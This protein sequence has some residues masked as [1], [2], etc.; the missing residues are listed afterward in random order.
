MIQPSASSGQTSMQQERDE[1]HELADRQLAADH[2]AAAE[3][4][5]GG[6]PERGQEEQAGRKYASTEPARIV[7]CRTASARPRKRVAHVVLAP[8][9]LHHL[10]PDDRLVGRLGEVA[11]ARLDEPRDRE[12]LVREDERE[13]RDRRHRQRRVEREPRVHDV[14]TIAAPVII[15]ALWT[16]WTTPQ[17]M[18]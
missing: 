11:L 12:E 3:E 10:D 17:P 9:R 15:I 7:S 8:E 16:P 14:S 2:V 4:E 13:D 18:K 5:H 6:D 1:E